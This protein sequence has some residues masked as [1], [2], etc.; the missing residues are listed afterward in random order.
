M[1]LSFFFSLGFAAFV[2]VLILLGVQ[3]AFSRSTKRYYS[4]AYVQ[5]SPEPFRN[6]I[7]GVMV[8][9]LSLHLASS[10]SSS[11][12]EEEHQFWYYASTTIYILLAVYQVKYKR[13]ALPIIL[14]AIGG[15]ILRYWNSSGIK[16]NELVQEHQKAGGEMNWQWLMYS[17]LVTPWIT[18]IAIVSVAISISL[19]V[20]HAIYSIRKNNK[21]RK[22]ALIE[23]SVSVATLVNVLVY[24]L[25]PEMLP[26]PF[27]SIH[28]LYAI[29]ALQ[30]VAVPFVTNRYWNYIMLRVFII[31]TSFWFLIERLQNYGAITIVILQ[32]LALVRTQVTHQVGV[33]NGVTATFRV[34]GFSKSDW[35]LVC[36]FMGMSAYY[37][38]GRSISVATIDFGG[39]YQGLTEYSPT[40]IAC[41]IF[42]LQYL[43]RLIFLVVAL[44]IGFNHKKIQ[45]SNPVL[46]KNPSAWTLKFLFIEFGLLRAPRMLVSSA[47]LLAMKDH[48]FIWSVFCPKYLY[49]LADT[50]FTIVASVLIIAVTILSWSVGY[51]SSRQVRHEHHYRRYE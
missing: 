42:L 14:V 35:L 46:D 31:L 49:E 33:Q 40:L 1:I 23:A 11:L 18:H 12:I 16:W 37:S 34:T 4:S 29:H 10:T 27:N 8:A 13:P 25:F 7:R 15:R 32:I 21:V 50:S 17:Q 6:F 51:P 3:L 20:L 38:F 44:M 9:F 22:I 24:K 28:F 41:L 19:I 48:L 36:H 43:P 5:S 30:F 45:G 39:V 47:M 26:Y 2:Q